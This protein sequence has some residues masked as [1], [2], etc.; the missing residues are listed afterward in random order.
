MGQMILTKEIQEKKL[1]NTFQNIKK[2]ITSNSHTNILVI[3]IPVRY[4]LRNNESMN[5]IIPKLNV[6]LQKLVKINPHSK[7]LET[8]KDINPA[9]KIETLVEVVKICVK[10]VVKR[11]IT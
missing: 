5:K 10:I 3:N 9:L 1:P 2:F 4:D 7:F 11:K 8:P 6:K